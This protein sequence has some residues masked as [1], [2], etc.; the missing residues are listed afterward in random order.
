MKIAVLGGAGQLGRHVVEALLEN[1]C[2][3][4]DIVVMTRKPDRAG[5]LAA[6]GVVVRSGD[7]DAP[8][9]LPG[10]LDG[11]ETVHAIPS[12][13]MPRQRVQQ[14]E[15]VLDAARRQGV[16]RF[17]STGLVGTSIHNPFFIMPYLVYAETAVRNSGLAWTLLRNGYYADPV[18]D[19]VPDILE[20]GTIPYPTGSGRCAYVARRDLGRATA[21]VLATS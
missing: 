13:A 11:V 9:S 18:V 16:R 10:V 12:F 6:R 2:G 1:G 17:V 4:N 21:A 20:M 8:E 19:W 5:D 7:Y 3:A 15:D 14:L